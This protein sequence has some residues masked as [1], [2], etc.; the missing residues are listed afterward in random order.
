MEITLPPGVTARPPRRSDL[1]AVQAL[2][3]AY[4]QRL[5]GEPLSDLEDLEADWERPSFDPERDA[6]L[7]LAGD[8]VVAHG[9]VSGA[10]RATG[11]VHPA[12]WGRGIGAGLVD[13][14]AA[15]VAAQGGS[16]V[17]QTVPDTDVAA[18]AL[19]RSRGWSPRWTSW[20][21]ELAPGDVVPARP[22]PAGYRLRELRPGQDEREAHRVI[23][24]AFSEW[25]DREPTTY[26]DWAAQVLGRPGFAPW[27]LLLVEDGSARVVGACYVVLSG[28]TGWVDQVAVDADHRR[29]GLAQSLLSAAYGAA[30]ARGATRSELSTD[31]RT[32]ALGLYE[33]L[34]MRAR[35]SY[36]HW[37]GATR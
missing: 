26:D 23:E 15:V 31:S 1:P 34:G 5:L 4:E 10:R 13:W 6:V 16:T 7:V 21:L 8:E 17:G 12:H 22:L 2:V 37:A 28:G 35:S 33:R 18:A 24:A 9:E 30:R 32:G 14:C 27:Q 3:E 36:T 20:V 11:C 25:P 29:R 19:F